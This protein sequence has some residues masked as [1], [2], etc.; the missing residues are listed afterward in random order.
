MS[1]SK[2]RL[3]HEGTI[4]SETLPNGKTVHRAQVTIDGRKF[5][6]PRVSR[7]A[8]ARPA[9]W[10][11]L[12]RK[13]A[14]QPGSP[15]TLS[16]SIPALIADR[17]QYEWAPKTVELA[18]WLADLV[19]GRTIGRLAAADVRSQD[20]VNWRLSLKLADSSL[21]RLQSMLE[22]MIKLLGGTAVA[23]KPRVREPDILILTRAQQVDLIERCV[24][25]RT[26][27]AMEILLALGIR[28]GEACGLMHE[29]R[30]EEGIYVRR[31]I[32]QLKGGATIRQLKTDESRAWVPLPP[33]LLDRIGP[34][35]EGYVLATAFGTPMIGSNLRRMLRSVTEGTEYE[36]VTVSGLRH[37]AAVNMLR[38]GVDPRM[39]ASITRHSVDTLLRIYHRVSPDGKKEAMEKTRVYRLGA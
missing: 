24:Q 6:G 33:E 3:N 8:D 29:D 17:L 18:N 26:R 36:R 30:F 7:K 4:F 15:V 9:L 23:A 32:Q 13:A 38:A 5:S 28:S 21:H 1:G 16:E 37:T 10:D 22:R 19:N 14:S 35:R 20:I 39:A 34:P 27:L 12:R 2:R 25:P 31:Q 11:K